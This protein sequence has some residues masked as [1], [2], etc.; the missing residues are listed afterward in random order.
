MR[1][2]AA[3]I[4]GVGAAAANN[5]TTGTTSA[6][7]GHKR[8]IVAPATVLAGAHISTGAEHNVMSHG[9]FCPSLAQWVGFW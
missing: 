3:S 7:R 8:A 2:I 9:H 5:V 6:P 1:F 4:S